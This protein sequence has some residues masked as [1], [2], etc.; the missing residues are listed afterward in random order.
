METLQLRKKTKLLFGFNITSLKKLTGYDNDNYLVVC[1]GNKYILK[2][3]YY[4]KKN[5]SIISAENDCLFYLNKSNQDIF[6]L[7]ILSVNNNGFEIITHR[8]KKYIIRILSYIEGKFL[9]ENKISEKTLKSLGLFIG[10]MSK[11]LMRYGNDKISSRILNW[12]IQN[13]KLNEKFIRYIKD[14][15]KRKIVLFYFQQFDEFVEP[16]LKELRRSIIHNDANEWNLLINKKKELSII[17]FGDLSESQLINEVAVAITYSTYGKNDPIKSGC[18]LLKSYNRIIKLTDLEI[19]LLYYLIASKLCI[20]VCNSA[21]SKEINPSNKYALISEKKAWK[22]LEKLIKISPKFAENEFRKATGRKPLKVKKI[23]KYIDERNSVISPIFSVSYDNP[24]AFERSAFQYMFD[25]E[26]KTYLDAYNNIPIVGHAHPKINDAI[27]RQ[28]KKLNTNTRY[29][30]D[31]LYR[32]AKKLLD[33][34][35]KILNKIYFVNSGSEASDLAIKM[36]LNHSKNKRI[37]VVENGYHGHTQTGTDISHYKYGNIKGQGLKD[38]ITHVPMPDLYRSIYDKNEKN[39]GRKYAIDATSNVKNIA[40]FISEPILGCG[41]QVPLPK[42]YLKI[43]YKKVRENK[44]VCISDEVQTGFGRLGK[45]FWG[46]EM[47]D[48]IPDIIILGKPMGNGH[49]IGAVVTTAKIANS[50][51]KGVEFFSSFGG[52]PVSCAVGL[53]V[54]NIIEEEGLQDNAKI[55]GNYYKNKLNSLKD[56][57]KVIGDVRGQGLFLGIEIIHKN[58]KKPNAKLAKYIKNKLRDNHILVGTDGPYNNVIKTKPPICF[59]KVDA[60]T[61]VDSIDMILSEKLT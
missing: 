37:M 11:L 18:I 29:L 51:E 56:K 49:P 31:N 22:M 15:S 20:S 41:G 14:P 36:A 48:V 32:Y 35:P 6:P 61:V 17:D 60:K 2:K 19:S 57:Y 46:F 28:I 7:P 52:N 13:L 40:A 24:I 39:I 26:G 5:E 44:G 10:K 43:L 1:K 8:R 12:D 16:K 42:N 59:E 54:L 4:S 38:H 50:F 45:Y 33:K 34:F 9:G 47:H 53:S 58:D 27:T 21:Y 55:V 30:H 25:N 23:K 3:Y